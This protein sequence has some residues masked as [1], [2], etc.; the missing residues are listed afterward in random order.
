[1]AG[2]VRHLVN[3]GGRYDARL[4]VPEERRGIF[5]KTELRNDPR[6]PSVS[7]DDLLVQRLRDAIA[8]CVSD[9]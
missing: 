1:M 4:V 2:K 6:G 7:I 5:G 8:G 3:R 9:E